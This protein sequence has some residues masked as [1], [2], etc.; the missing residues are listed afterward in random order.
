V[1]LKGDTMGS[2]TFKPIKCQS[3][4]EIFFLIDTDICPFCKK[5]IYDLPD[6]FKDIFT[7]FNETFNNNEN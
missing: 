4:G 2:E 3:C 1:E 5:R 7:N 6:Y